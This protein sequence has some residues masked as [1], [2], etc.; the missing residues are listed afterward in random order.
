MIYKTLNQ[1]MFSVTL[2]ICVLYAAVFS[3]IK[4]NSGK[5]SYDI[6]RANIYFPH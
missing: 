5:T 4:H 2:G 3:V 1:W 6:A